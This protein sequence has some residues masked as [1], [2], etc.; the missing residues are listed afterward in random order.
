MDLKDIETLSFT[1]K[2]IFILLIYYFFSID[3]ALDKRFLALEKRLQVILEL[4]VLDFIGQ[5][6]QQKAENEGW[7]QELGEMLE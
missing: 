4:K 7:Q 5:D 3:R 6:K 2:A 1:S